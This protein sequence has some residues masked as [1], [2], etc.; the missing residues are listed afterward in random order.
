MTPRVALYGVGTDAIAQH[1]QRDMYLPA[2]RALGTEVTG[3]L[4]DGARAD[5]FRHDEGLARLDIDTATTDTD[6]LVA[7]PDLAD[8]E[9]LDGVLARCSDSGVP[10]LLDKPTLLPT[11]TLHD[12]A[13][14]HPGVIAA[15]HPRFHAGLS[16]IAGR[17]RAGELG[18][19]HAV[20]GELLVA[21]ADGPHP[22]G[23]LR[24]LG[25]YALDVVQSLLGD[26]H[27]HG[28]LFI[29]PAAG[30]V[31]E[32]LSMIARLR[33]DIVVTLLVG[34]SSVEAPEG[35]VHRYRLLGSHGQALI[36]LSAPALDLLGG[37]RIPFG[38]NS[39]E[40][41]LAAVLAG[42]RIPDLRVAASLGGVMD[43][44]ATAQSRG[45]ATDF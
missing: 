11:A 28:A 16:A 44:L 12:W 15:H 29:Q 40:R 18:L 21:N 8:L 1:H 4:A 5:R 13:V 39:V 45:V 25:V 24:N 22:A 37:R 17:I 33:P 14:R 31:G 36:D 3:L 38:P 35:T 10:V 7:C 41:M 30:S 42:G 32:S 2:L 19:L 26:L 23:E 6:L 27:G 20:H 43:A 9:A 34:R